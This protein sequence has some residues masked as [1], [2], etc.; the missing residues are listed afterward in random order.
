MK[1]FAYVSS[2]VLLVL[3]VGVFLMETQ[4]SEKFSF[5][6]YRDIPGITE[7]EI[8]AIEQLKLQH[9]YFIYGMLLCDEAFYRENGEIAGFAVYMTDWLTELFGIPFIPAIFSWGDLLLG[10]DDGSI[11]F[12]GDLTQSPERDSLYAMTAPIA[13][14]SLHIVRLYDDKPLE[15]IAKERPLRIIFYKD[16]ATYQIFRDAKT[17]K[18]FIPIFVDH[19]DTVYELLLSGEADAFIDEG[20]IALAFHNSI[21]V[22]SELISPFIFSNVAFSTKDPTLVPIVNVV[23]KAMDNGGISIIAELYARG[24]EEFRRH[25]MSVMLTDE[26]NEFI[27][28]NPV[29][30]VA[31]EHIGYPISF[32]NNHEGEYQGIAQDVLGNVT[33]LTGLIFELIESPY[34]MHLSNVLNMLE[35]GEANIAAGIIRPE[36]IPGQFIWSDVFFTD[37]YALLS[38]FE[39]SNISI[40]EVLYL[41]VGII[42]DSTYHR[43]FLYMFPNHQNLLLYPH[44]DA[45]LEALESGEVDMAFSSRGGL[46]RLT[47]FHERTGFRANFIFDEP[48]GITFAFNADDEILRS[49]I[50][51]SLFII[52]TQS[53]S[54]KWM[55]KTF[56]YSTRLLQARLPFLIGVI[57]LLAFVIVL[58]FVLFNKTR[59]EGQRLRVLVAERTHALEVETATINAIFDTIPDVLFC[60]DLEYRHIRINKRFEELFNLK[61]ENVL[62]KTEREFLDLPEDIANDWRKWD[63]IVLT[64]QIPAKIEEPIPAADGSMRIFETVKVPLVISGKVIGLLGLCRDVTKR[65]ETETEALNAS[66]AKSTFIANISHEIRTPMNSIIGFSELSLEDELPQKTRKYLQQIIENAQWLLQIINDV[67]DISKIESGKLELEHVPFSLFE[68]FSQCKSAIMLKATEKGVKLHFY[69]EPI[70]GNTWLMGDPVRLRQIFLNLLTNAVKFTEKGTIRVTSTVK[71]ATENSR[72]IYYEVKDTGIGMTQ[73]QI[74]RIGEPFMQADVSVTRRYGGTGLGIPIIKNFIEMMGGKLKIESKA[75]LGSTFSFELTFDVAPAQN[76]K[77]QLFAPD[78][79][80]EKPCFEGEVLVCEDNKMN[81]MV[82]TEHLSRVG[83]NATIA[84]NGQIGVDMVKER[85]LN[86][87]KPFDLI[88]MD[89][90]MPVMDGL[91][92]AEKI[93]ALDVETPIVALTAN[94]MVTDKDIYRQHGMDYCLGKPFVSQELWECL[95]KFFKPKATEISEKNEVSE[96]KNKLK[97]RF[98]KDNR[99]KFQEI[100]E[101]L[102]SKDYIKAHRLAHTLKS[103][104]ALIGETQL[105][106]IS[107]EIESLLANGKNRTSDSHWHNLEEEL[108]F[109]LSE[110]EILDQENEDNLPKAEKSAEEVNR[111]FDR[112]EYL[113]TGRNHECLDLLDDIRGIPS[114]KELVEQIEAYDFKE[115]LQTL[116]IIRKL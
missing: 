88:F 13:Q 56:D 65:K 82:I 1:I 52:D 9:S 112:L 90:H 87:K 63:A 21:N 32:F 53:I 70:P 41:N 94:V 69:S 5:A 46:L 4:A 76:T 10:L 60:K 89:I 92:A 18:D 96:F 37:N 100:K 23:Q 55:S 74:D 48:Y 39:M 24:M 107:A 72:T 113:L 20:S 26:E 75:G 2:I 33:T 27:K 35:E 44:L 36:D 47:G 68:I 111:L 14:R 106:D 115:A 83:L 99:N 54:D 6:S 105:H 81:Q 116:A 93:I 71:N 15:D 67:L 11:N 34:P 84:E 114:T 78:K 97:L 85:I 77:S 31:A 25:S 79:K 57:I 104:A 103:S 59:N 17:N 8:E 49:I 42:Q 109:V 108:D 50:N 80:M 28:Q 66:K 3:F 29:I 73:E 38:R 19:S 98:L 51:K 45:L 12:T 7:E 86:N 91:E 95:F 43:L 110:L 58:V 101:S 40:N 16:S 30:R 64:K 102:D 22:Y 62:G 61:R